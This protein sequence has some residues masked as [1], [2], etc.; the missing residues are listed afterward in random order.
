ML[1]LHT[2]LHAADFSESSEVA[3]RETGA[4]P[5]EDYDACA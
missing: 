3:A 1:P 2:I 5:E 4:E